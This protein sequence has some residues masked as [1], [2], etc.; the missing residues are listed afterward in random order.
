[1]SWYVT[2]QVDLDSTKWILTDNAEGGVFDPALSSWFELHLGGE[3]SW[4]VF[5]RLSDA[6]WADAESIPFGRD[7]GVVLDSTR[8]TLIVEADEGPT[9]LFLECAGFGS[10]ERTNNSWAAGAHHLCHRHH[11]DDIVSGEPSSRPQALDIRSEPCG[12]GLPVH[13]SNQLPGFE[14]LRQD[15][16]MTTRAHFIEDT[17]NVEHMDDP[18]VMHVSKWEEPDYDEWLKKI[19]GAIS[20]M[21]ASEAQLILR[22][23]CPRS[24]MAATRLP[25][26]FE[27]AI[28]PPQFTEA[29]HIRARG[30]NVADAPATCDAEKHHESGASS[31]VRDS[32]A[33]HEMTGDGGRPLRTFGDG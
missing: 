7:V 24:W 32:P 4:D 28:W 18:V 17:P 16:H 29:L 2:A 33:S 15:E 13:D 20:R 11:E 3:S 14:L 9:A 23:R 5:E 6:S 19:P 10:M 25:C 12:N 1:M 8:T 30:G 26:L 21:S 31:Q 27:G 22:D